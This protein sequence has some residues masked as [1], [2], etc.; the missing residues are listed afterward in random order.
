MYPQKILAS[1]NQNHEQKV[2]KAIHK[3]KSDNKTLSQSGEQVL[4]QN[5]IKIGK[6]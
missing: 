5:R 2:G 6:K 3:L 4:A 1:L